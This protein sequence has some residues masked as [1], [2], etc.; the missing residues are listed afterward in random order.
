MTILPHIV[1]VE[2]GNDINVPVK[3]TTR[4]PDGAEVEFS[5]CFDVSLNIDLSD[6]KNFAVG[7]LTR[8]VPIP[9]GCRAI[10]IRAHGISVTK[11]MLTFTSHDEMP[12]K[13]SIVLASYRKLRHLEPSN[14]E[15]VLALGSSRIL[16][17]EGGPLPWINKPS[18]HYRKSIFRL[19]SMSYE[20][21]NGL[22]CIVQSMLLIKRSLPSKA[23]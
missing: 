22:S 7:P 16:V 13:D 4:L 18:S 2:E 14:G 15:T 6:T 12:I 21:F 10:P 11:L 23:S 3:M 20:N 19:Q 5:D 9:K 17:F 8:D 1:E